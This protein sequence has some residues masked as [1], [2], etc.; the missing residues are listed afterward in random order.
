MVFCEITA[1]IRNYAELMEENEDKGHRDGICKSNF[2]MPAMQIFEE[3]GRRSAVFIQTIKKRTAAVI[4]GAIAPDRT[5]AEEC[6]T[7]L[8][9]LADIHI[10]EVRM[11]ETTMKAMRDMLRMADRQGFIEDDDDFLDAFEMEDLSL[12]FYCGE[13]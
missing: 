6:L 10:D 4:L 5:A 13:L 1:K 7:R 11:Q 3:S 2:H 8:F 12:L 9:E